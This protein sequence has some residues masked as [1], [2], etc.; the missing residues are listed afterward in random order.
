M[1]TC[2]YIPIFKL[3]ISN[4]YVNK[5]KFHYNTTHKNLNNTLFL[6]YIDS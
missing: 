4:L 1:S 5:D 3:H 2:K 6:N